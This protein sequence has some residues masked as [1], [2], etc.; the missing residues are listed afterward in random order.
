MHKRSR[1]LPIEV[2]LMV[3]TSHPNRIIGE[4]P[5]L[6][7]YI[8]RS[9]G[10]SHVLLMVQQSEDHQFAEKNLRRVSPPK[11]PQNNCHSLARIDYHMYQGNP[12][13]PPKCR[14]CQE[15]RP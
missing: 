4:I 11:R 3:E 6:R 7:I 10:P 8:Y 2:G 13:V 1:P 12:R 14:P 15:I 5:F 9:V